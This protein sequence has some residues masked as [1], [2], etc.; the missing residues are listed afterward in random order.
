MNSSDK[1]QKPNI[2]IIMPDQ[3]RASSLPCYGETQIPTPHIDRLANEGC[4]MTQALST[5]PVCT[6]CR[7]MLFTGRHPQTTGHVVNFMHTRHDEIGMADVLNNNGY[8]C[9]YIGK[10]HLHSGSFPHIEDADFVP[11]GRDRLGFEFWRG[12]NFHT[13]YNNG[14]VNIGDW[15][16]E[17]WDGYETEALPRYLETFIDD[18][19]AEKQQPFFAVVSAH[20][21]HFTLYDEWAPEKYYKDLPDDLVLPDNVPDEMRAKV[22]DD[23]RNYFAM[24]V[25]VDGMVG[26][27]VEQLEK[28]GILDN[29]IILFCADHGTAMGSHGMPA[30]DKKA[31]YEH[32]IK[33]PFIIRYP[34]KFAAYSTSQALVTPVDIMPSLLSL[35]DIPIPRSVEG[36]DQSQDW[37]TNGKGRDAALTMNFIRYHDFL[38]DGNEWRGV[39][40]HQYSYARWLDGRC[41]LYDIQTDP[42][43]MHNLAD[44][45]AFLAQREEL[46]EQ[47]Q[48]LL[49]QRADAFGPGSSYTDWFDYQRRVVRNSYG[50]LGHPEGSPDW[51]LLQPAD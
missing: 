48:Q 37:C 44:D 14:T 16:F 6:P 1:D 46:E 27:I 40:T 17:H 38:E 26:D 28:R 43:Q 50:D 15:S 9:G 29:T 20:P 24:T 2:V 39:R 42:L 18:P 45:P 51:S 33:I 35:C 31:P 36:K 3:L 8:R 32:S 30:Y 25:A 5:C 41:V 10:W 12:Y 21:C 47:L 13:Q 34:E 49:Q 11:Q 4:R 19:D 22:I 7:S 23:Y